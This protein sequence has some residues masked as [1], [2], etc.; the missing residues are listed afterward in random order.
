MDAAA[1]KGP[2]APEARNPRTPPLAQAVRR[3][4]EQFEELSGWPADRVTG[5]RRDG[6]GWSVLVDVVELERVPSSTSVLATYRVDLDWD[7]QLT[8]YQRLRRFPR[9]ATDRS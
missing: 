3:A 8:A 4:V 2:K 5:V 7:G 6:D 9:N 1:D